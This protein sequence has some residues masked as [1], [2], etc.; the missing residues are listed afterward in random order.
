M[1]SVERWVE[2]ARYDLDTAR[3]AE[4]ES[5]PLCS[6]CCQQAVENALKAVI[7]QKTR[8]FP[9]R[10]HNLPRLAEIGGITMDQD[11]EGF[12]GELSGYYVQTRYPAEIASL[13]G[14]LHRETATDVFRKTEEITQWLFSMLV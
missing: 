4:Y 7:V 6:F 5:L 8:D 14:A 2:Q 11:R 1:N 9:P 10:L 13:G 12:M 3:H